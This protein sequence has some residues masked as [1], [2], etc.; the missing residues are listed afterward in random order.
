MIS[1]LPDAILNQSVA[2]SIATRV[3]PT[4]RTLHWSGLDWWVKTGFNG[5]GPNWF[6][7]STSNVLVDAQGRLHLRITH[8]NSTWYCAEIVSHRTLGYG[9]YVFHDNGTPDTLDPNVVLGQFT[10]SNN[11][12]LTDRE[13]DLEYSRWS[14]PADTNNAQFVI[15]PYNVTGNL[16]RLR[17]PSGATNS[18]SLFDLQTNVISFLSYT[19]NVALAAMTTNALLNP[20]FETGAASNTDV[21]AAHW[22][23][24]G[25]TYRTPTNQTFAAVTALKGAYAMKM[26]G[27]FNPGIGAVGVYQD[28]T[29]GVH[30]GQLWQLTGFGLNWSGD[31]MTGSNGYGVAQ[32][33]FMDSTNGFIQ[34]IEG[35]HYGTGTPTDLWQPFTVAA[36]A[37][38]GAVGVRIYLLHLGQAGNSGSIWWDDLAAAPVPTSGTVA[39]WT[40]AGPGFSSC[41]ENVRLNLWLNNGNAPQNGL[42]TEVVVSKFEFQGNDT[43]G[44]G[45]PDLW[46][47]AHGLNPANPSDANRDDDGDGFTNLQEY[48]A[49]TDPA[50]PANALRIV[51]VNAVGIDNVITFTTVLDHNYIAEFSNSLTPPN[52]TAL[53][54]NVAGTGSTAQIIDHGAATNA[55]PRF[56]HVRL[57]P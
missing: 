37:P 6:S 19:G 14:N 4:T 43:D 46:E 18:I 44:D 13:V 45:M 12:L 40:Y 54:T 51:G 49:G 24:F 31:P 29:A 41:D 17:V 32:I 8:S 27:P 53:A 30:P 9:N 26:F 47:L 7:D 42:E 23:Q 21:N 55:P 22:L 20:G 56:Y 28:I 36:T 16:V 10:W 5:P 38:A 33:V 35:P 48:L 2:N 39:Q 3:A 25:S 34:T 52:W 57:V 15:Q 11:P 50:N 1:C